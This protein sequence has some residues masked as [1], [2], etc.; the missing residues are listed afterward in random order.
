MPSYSE[1]DVTAAIDDILDGRGIRL[2]ARDHGIPRTTIGNSI[3]G[4][5]TH[6]E[7]SEDLQRLSPDLE[8]RLA[9]FALTQESLGYAMTHAQIKGIAQK[10]LRSGGDLKPLGRHWMDG[11]LRRNPQLKTKKGVRIE[12]KRTN[13]ASAENIEKFFKILETVSWVKSCNIYNVDETGIMEGQGINGLVVGSSKHNSKATYVKGNQDRTWTSI[14]KCISATGKALKP[15]IIFK[16]ASIQVQWFAKEFKEPWHYTYS[17]NGWT[18]NDIAL[19]WLE[20]TFIPQTAP[21]DPTEAR[22][23]ILNGHGS[24]A[25]DDFMYN[26]FRHNIFLVYLPPH[27][28]HVLQP[29]DVGVFSA[30]KRAYRRYLAD[31]AMLT[32]SSPIG[33]LNFLRCYVKARTDGISENNIKAGFRGTGIWPRNKVKALSSRQVVAP[34]RPLTPEPTQA[35][36]FGIQTPKGRLDAQKLLDST[37]IKSPT[38]RLAF[39]KLA[40]ALEE[41]DASL[42]MANEKIRATDSAAVNSIRQF[43]SQELN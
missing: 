20:K 25:T 17:A 31:L 7:A 19:E 12:Y 39:R 24:H 33:K 41:K 2:A 27:S 4:M 1:A 32:D 10:I 18:S 15:L 22:L 37:G 6:Q 9:Q 35:P 5:D 36:S 11:F 21:E 34:K 40:K 43:S 28:S 38:T 13:G 8:T 26:C 30:L 29:L 16:A 14:V 23:L 3:K 42:V